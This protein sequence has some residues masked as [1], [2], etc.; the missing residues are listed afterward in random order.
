M[1]TLHELE[2][3]LKYIEYLYNIGIDA[4]IVQ[5]IGKCQNYFKNN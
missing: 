5:D 3:C 4:V 2:E 1:I